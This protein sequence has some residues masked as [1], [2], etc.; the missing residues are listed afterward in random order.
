MRVVQSILV[1]GLHTAFAWAWEIGQT[2]QTASGFVHG[3]NATKAPGVSEYLGI[4]Y[5]QPP[6]GPLR[7]APPVPYSGSGSINATQFV[8]AL[9]SYGINE[10]FSLTL[11]QPEYSLLQFTGF[12][13]KYPSYATLNLLNN[14]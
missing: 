6:V 2:V 9:F 11:L 13:T 12:S 10:S 3:Q 4:P 7:F 8:S 1:L 14:G 5:A